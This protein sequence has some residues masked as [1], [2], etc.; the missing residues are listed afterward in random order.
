MANN[1]LRNI[2][3]I[4]GTAFFTFLLTRPTR[5][6]A[7][8][9]EEINAVANLSNFSYDSN[10]NLV[11]FDIT[12]TGSQTSLFF[13]DGITSITNIDNP[14]YSDVAAGSS[15]TGLQ[16][17]SSIYEEIL[18]IGGFP[19]PP[20]TGIIKVEPNQTITLPLEVPINQISLAGTFDVGIRTG[21]F[22]R[23][24][25]FIF[26][27]TQNTLIDTDVFTLGTLT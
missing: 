17:L 2:M 24:P 10:L 5:A 27:D 26:G 6:Q 7:R 18:P 11:R 13:I 14:A 3:L 20:Y 25:E 12:N 8:N 16:A 21:I 1:N 9:P 23:C 22:V 4:G 19:G 15:V